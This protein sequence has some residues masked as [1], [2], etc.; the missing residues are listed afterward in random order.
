M[1][2]RTRPRA[3]KVPAGAHSVHIPRQRR[4]HSSA[5]PFVVVI[6]ERPSLL[7]EAA[8]FLGLWLW[9]NRRSL[10]PLAL[11][12]VAAGVAAVLHLWAWWSGLVLAPV[13]AAPLVWLLIAQHRHPVP[14][15][16]LRW[17][18]GLAVAAAAAVAWLAL[19][20]GFGPL[21]APLPTV[22]LVLTAAGQVGWLIVRRKG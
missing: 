12:T 7:R 21:A 17:R 18:L 10:A 20:A 19:A 5:Q 11:A 14:P 3:V 22:W 4:G 2:R 8:G 9:D 1:T 15:S 16:V 6:P 13:A